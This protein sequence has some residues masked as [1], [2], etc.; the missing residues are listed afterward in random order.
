MF[1]FL[2]FLAVAD[3]PVQKIPHEAR[4]KEN[5]KINLQIGR[6]ML[7]MDMDISNYIMLS[8]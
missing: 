7:V 3:T 4:Q 6:K 1:R 5:I 2:T 8:C